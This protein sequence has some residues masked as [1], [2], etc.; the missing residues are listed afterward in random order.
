MLFFKHHGEQI[1][2]IA[3]TFLD[4]VYLNGLRAL[5]TLIRCVLLSHIACDVDSVFQVLPTVNSFD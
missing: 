3:P 5:L 1:R 4:L 2:C